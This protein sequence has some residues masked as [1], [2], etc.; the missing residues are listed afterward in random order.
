MTT[1]IISIVCVRVISN[2]PRWS[3]INEGS[4]TFAHAH[5]QKELFAEYLTED[6]VVLYPTREQK[7]PETI[8]RKNMQKIRCYMSANLHDD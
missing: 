1:R 4:A 8:A 6:R 5:K 3:N 7:D 2:T